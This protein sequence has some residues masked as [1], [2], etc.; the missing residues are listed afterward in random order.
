MKN[1]KSLLLA[2]GMLVL[3]IFL[4]TANTHA[5]ERVPRFTPDERNWSEYDLTGWRFGIN[6]GLYFANNYSAQY[7]SGERFNENNIE[8]V[9][10]N[11]YW[12]EEIF[13]E[14]NS[15]NIYKTTDENIP[16]AWTSSLQE[17]KRQ[18]AIAD[19]EKAWWIYYPLDLQYNATIMPGFYVK[20]NFNNTT[21]VFVQ[22][23]YVKLVTSG[24]FQMVIDSVTYTS[25]PALRTG[26]IRGELEQVTIDVGISKFYR[27]GNYTSVFIET[28]LQINSSRVLESRVQI[29][30]QQYTLIN[31]YGSSG[32]VP[33]PGGNAYEYDIYQGGIG[34]G[35]F[36]NGGM[37]FILNESV[38]IDPGV[39]VAWKNV[40][41]E[42]YRDFAPD[43]Y[44][45]L[46]LIF[47]LF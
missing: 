21:G 36:L 12:Y 38:S 15:N 42:G 23:N 20:Y 17:W 1:Q 35:I 25:E 43:A 4:A 22:S 29:G 41:L 44:V 19:G 11:K 2:I 27:T 24:V 7:F 47:D 10:N 34:F 31:R 14:L 33:G 40:N 37:K 6:M 18:Y 3:I 39:Q 45:Y 13:Q 16:Q 9:L 32:Y 28:G 46:R 5:Q 8:Y 26:Y 30:K